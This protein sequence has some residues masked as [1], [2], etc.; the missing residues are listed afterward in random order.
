MSV[1]RDRP[2]DKNNQNPGSL[3]GSNI[4]RHKDLRDLL[5]RFE[6]I[7][8]LERIQGAD[9]NLEMA[10]L[11]EM[12]SARNPGRSP[13]LLFENITDYPSNYRVL[14]GAANS[15]KRLA[16]VLGFPEPNSEMDLVQSYRDR[17]KEEFQLIPPKEVEEGP[18]LENIDRDDEVDLYK[19]Q[20]PQIS[21]G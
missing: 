16:I 4:P 11:S 14:S 1:T 9:W 19:F 2:L 8:E 18:I 17:M 10:A 7:G 21:F 12:V 6:E 3:L 13:A 15:F 20:H 5:V